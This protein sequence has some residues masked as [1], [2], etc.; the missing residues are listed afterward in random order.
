MF[1][2]EPNLITLYHLMF[3]NRSAQSVYQGLIIQLCSDH[4]SGCQQIIPKLLFNNIIIYKIISWRLSVDFIM[5]QTRG[6]I[7]SDSG[8]TLPTNL[9]K[10]LTLKRGN[11]SQKSW[12]TLSQNCGAAELP[13]NSGTTFPFSFYSVDQVGNVSYYSTLQITLLLYSCQPRYHK[14]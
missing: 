8:V 13:P 10:R 3:S 14:E 11:V 12:E 5:R 2:D 1:D 6:N 9:G 4:V 7:T